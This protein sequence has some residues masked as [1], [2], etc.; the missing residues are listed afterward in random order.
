MYRQL[1][2]QHPSDYMPHLR[3]VQKL[4]ISTV[5]GR[6]DSSQP[7]SEKVKFGLVFGCSTDGTGKS[8]V[9]KAQLRQISHIYAIMQRSI[10]T[11][12]PHGQAHQVQL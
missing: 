1:L 12:V 6:F 9:D 7:V 10:D 8:H 2:W 11:G 3:V 5:D 4:L